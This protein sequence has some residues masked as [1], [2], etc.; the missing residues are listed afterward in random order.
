MFNNSPSPFMQIT[1]ISNGL[2]VR[3]TN[4]DAMYCANEKA[5][6][7]EIISRAVRSKMRDED[8]KLYDAQSNQAQ[9]SATL[10]KQA[11]RI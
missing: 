11:G 7:D 10:N 8:S 2:L 6:S 5:L 9:S 1:K 3:Y 4:G